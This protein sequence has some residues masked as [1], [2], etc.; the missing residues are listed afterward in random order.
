MKTTEEVRQEFRHKGITVAGWARK[1]GFPTQS[2]R[3]V[4]RGDA[5]CWY[6]NAHKIAVMLGIKD[7]VIENA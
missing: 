5:K 2:V 4:M 6:G 7:G 3:R 1:H